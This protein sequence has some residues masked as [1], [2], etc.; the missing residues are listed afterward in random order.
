MVDHLDDILSR[1]AVPQA[2]TN[3]AQ[4]IIDAARP[5]GGTAKTTPPRATFEEW[6]STLF[7][8]LL[9]PRPAIAMLMLLLV[10][11]MI[12]AYIGEPA[13]EA[14]GYEF[15]SVYVE[16]DFNAGEWL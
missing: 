10:G 6:L 15:P 9:V 11:T 5:L 13:A 16:D 8:G 12:G 3:L 7:D 2:P 4:R 14:Q 1:R